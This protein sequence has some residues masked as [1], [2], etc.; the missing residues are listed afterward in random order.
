MNDL[1]DGWLRRSGLVDNSRPAADREQIKGVARRGGESLNPEPQDYNTTAVLR[2]PR[3]TATF[4]F[5]YESL[6]T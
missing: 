6:K 4:E 2:K 3:V 1:M 5:R